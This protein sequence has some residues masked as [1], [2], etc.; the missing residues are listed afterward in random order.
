MVMSM[1]VIETAKII[2]AST[3]NFPLPPTAV[4]APVPPVAVATV[5]LPV[6][7]FRRLAVGGT[8]PPRQGSLRDLRTVTG[9]PHLD[10]HGRPGGRSHRPA[11][12]C[13][14]HAVGPTG[15]GTQVPL[16]V[17]PKE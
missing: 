13:T 4:A 7:T 5:C 17:R 11:V 9:T 6:P 8:L 2:A 3:R 14:T 16:A 10:E 12:R 1:N 15:D